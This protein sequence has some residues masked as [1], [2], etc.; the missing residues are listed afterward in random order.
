MIKLLATIKESS[1]SLI[2]I[3]DKLPASYFPVEDNIPS[4][5]LRSFENVGNL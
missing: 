1:F 2:G 4:K 3:V 5:I